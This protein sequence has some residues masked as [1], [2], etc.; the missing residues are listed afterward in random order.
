MSVLGI[1]RVTKVGSGAKRMS[2]SAYVVVG[3]MQGRIGLGL[4][5]SRTVTGAIEQATTRAKDS[6]VC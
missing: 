2:F 3:D 4:G 1:R 5:K 6:D